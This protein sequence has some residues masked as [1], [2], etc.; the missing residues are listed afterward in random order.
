MLASSQRLGNSYSRQALS[1]PVYNGMPLAAAFL[2]AWPYNRVH[3]TV[4]C[5]KMERLPFTW[6]YVLRAIEAGIVEQTEIHGFLGMPEHSVDLWLKQLWARNAIS[7]Q[8]DSAWQLTDLGKEFLTSP[9]IEKIVK[10]PARIVWDC[11]RGCV[12]DVLYDDLRVKDSRSSTDLVLQATHRIPASRDLS[13]PECQQYLEYYLDELGEALDGAELLYLNYSTKPTLA[14]KQTYVLLYALDSTKYEIRVWNNESYDNESAGLIRGCPIFTKK[15]KSMFNENHV[16]DFLRRA[17]VKNSSSFNKLQ[18][19]HSIF[20]KIEGSKSSI[21]N[22]DIKVSESFRTL[23][24]QGILFLEKAL[25]ECKTVVQIVVTE[26]QILEWDGFKEL[27]G[28]TLARGAKCEIVI[29]HSSSNK[30]E[31]IVRIKDSLTKAALTF[32]SATE[33]KDARKKLS[34]IPKEIR[35]PSNWIPTIISDDNWIWCGS[36]I[37]PS[38]GSINAHFG[39]YSEK[40]PMVVQ[41]RDLISQQILGNDEQLY[42]QVR[43]DKKKRRTAAK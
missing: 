7:R 41:V 25:S 10:L 34:I 39:F 14:Y 3:S 36:D 33:R 16:I 18:F 21:G 31:R 32:V 24:A 13:L 11:I 19:Q 35:Y 9:D 26:T 8:N 6:L 29:A 27:V 30:T 40:R 20:S 12:S 17:N 15:I 22:N 42:P 43:V 38:A 37:I 4:E 5:R 23:P 28:R 2:I 1:M